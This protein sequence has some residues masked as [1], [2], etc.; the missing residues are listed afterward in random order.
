MKRFHGAVALFALL[1]IS[2]CGPLTFPMVT[3]LD[4]EAQQT[5]EASWKN[6]LTPPDRLDRMLLLDT[7]IVNRFHQSG[8]D[9]L[10]M[11]SEKTVGKDHVTMVVHFD[12]KRPERDSFTITIRNAWGMTRRREHYSGAE[13]LDRV[14]QLTDSLAMCTGPD[15][16]ASQPALSEEEKALAAWLERIAAATRPAE[17]GD[18]SNYE[19]GDQSN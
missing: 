13:V 5:V 2:G 14:D 8:V 4:P 18:Q 16:S 9:R 10:D 12:R 19:N 11:V 1:A 17:N 15:A 7:L 3:R 6:M